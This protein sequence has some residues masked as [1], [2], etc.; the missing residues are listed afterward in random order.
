M[1]T[2]KITFELSIDDANLILTSLAN[3]PFKDVAKLINDLQG[4]AQTQLQPAP[5]AEVK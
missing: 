2:K 3:M 5:E 4:Q 1:E